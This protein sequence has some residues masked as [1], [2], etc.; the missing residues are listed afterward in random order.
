M[1][2]EYRIHLLFIVHVQRVVLRSVGAN[3]GPSWAGLCKL[4]DI[5]GWWA[6][7]EHADPGGFSLFV[8]VP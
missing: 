8:Y 6:C 4:L 7:A 5:C 1:Q 3:C 2:G